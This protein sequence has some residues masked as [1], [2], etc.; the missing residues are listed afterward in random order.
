VWVSPIPVRT[1]RAAKAA[2]LDVTLRQRVALPGFDTEIQ[3]YE[4]R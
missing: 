3:R 1:E 2:G 4:K